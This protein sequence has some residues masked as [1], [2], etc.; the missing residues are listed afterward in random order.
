MKDRAGWGLAVTACVL[1][2]LSMLVP[3]AMAQADP[4]PPDDLQG[5]IEQYR[6][7]LYFHSQEIFRPQ[8]VDVLLENARFS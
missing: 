8:P 6:P 5:L 3:A 2:A 1:C 7:V 4:S